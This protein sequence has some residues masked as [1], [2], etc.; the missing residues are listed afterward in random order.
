MNKAICN[1]RVKRL[2]LVFAKSVTYVQALYSFS[3]KCK[4]RLETEE[5]TPDRRFQNF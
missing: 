4:F 2:S 3:G 5:E 1:K